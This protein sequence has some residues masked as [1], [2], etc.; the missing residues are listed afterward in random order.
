[1]R[2]GIVAGVP[3]RMMR[4]GFVGEWGYEIHVPA[5]YGPGPVGRA[6]G[7]RQASGIGA[8][9]VEAQRL[10]RLEKGHLIVSQDTDGLTHPFEVGMDWAVKMDKP[11][12]VGK[13]SLQILQKLPL[14]RRLAGF[15]LAENHAGQVPLECHLI[16]DGGEIVGRVTSISWSPHVG[17]YIGLAF[18]PPAMAEPG[19]PIS[20]RVTDGSMV[21]AETCATPFFDPRDQR[22]K[23]AE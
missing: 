7:G 20:I 16:I 18:V 15:M 3:A 9:G 11:F 8:F 17:R 4:V 12:F 21:A 2:S 23:E 19:T 5:E 13:R 6:D 14:K 10:L 1:V 22:Q